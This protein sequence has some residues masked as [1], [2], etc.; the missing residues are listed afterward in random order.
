MKKHE[1]E[2]ILIIVKS[3]G[4]EALNLKIYK[5]GTL[6]RRGCG[7]LPPIPITGISFTETSEI[8]DKLMEKVPQKVLDEPINY[9]EPEIHAPLEYILAF[10]GVSK[11]G[12]T[13][14]RAEWTKSTGIRFLLDNDSSFRHPLLEFLDGMALEALAA[15]NSWYFDIIMMAVQKVKSNALPDQTII[16]ASKTENELNQDLNHYV[17]QTNPSDL[18]FFADNKVY[19][20]STGLEYHILFDISDDSVRYELKPVGIQ[21]LQFAEPIPQK[22]KK[23]DTSKV[24]HPNEEKKWWKW[25]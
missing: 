21:G 6:G 14:E 8:F 5:D 23:K 3:G 25:W 11:N 19:A 16:A 2:Q 17:Q 12:E 18:Q 9:Q 10:F 24:E 7:G 15:T 4:E 13:G 1:V 20:D 22:R